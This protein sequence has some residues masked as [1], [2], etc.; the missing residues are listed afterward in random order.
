MFCVASVLHDSLHSRLVGLDFS[1]R[2]VLAAG[3]KDDVT[4]PTV[5]W[6]CA[7]MTPPS[8]R[9]GSRTLLHSEEGNCGI[10]IL[11]THTRHRHRQ[12]QDTPWK[13]G[14]TTFSIK[15]DASSSGPHLAYIMLSEKK[16]DPL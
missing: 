15:P 4:T 3:T 11:D 8:A 7:K 2:C 9:Q 5:S 12:R 1:A 6:L 13:A 10:K 16:G 14:I